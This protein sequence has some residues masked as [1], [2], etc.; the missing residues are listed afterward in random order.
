[1][2]SGAWA[3][4]LAS[5]LFVL[6]AHYVHIAAGAPLFEGLA[7]VLTIACLQ[8]PLIGLAI[9]PVGLLRSRLQFRT[10]AFIQLG[11]VVAAVA[12][13]SLTQ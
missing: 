2:A 7:R 6:V 9:V 13:L 3:A 12:K 4:I 5:G 11:A 8:L 1:M 10:L